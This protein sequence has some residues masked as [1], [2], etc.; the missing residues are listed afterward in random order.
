MKMN[1]LGPVETIQMLSKPQVVLGLRDKLGGDLQTAP[2]AA[3]GKAP[4]VQLIGF[5]TERGNSDLWR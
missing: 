3:G 2:A 4:R 1:R 5:V